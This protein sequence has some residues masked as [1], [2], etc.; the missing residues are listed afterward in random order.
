M[1]IHEYADAWWK[2]GLEDSL[3]QERDDVEEWFGMVRL[4]PAGSGYS[5]DPRPAYVEV[6][7]TWEP[8][9]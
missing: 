5:T 7:T 3:S 4:V 8:L 6:S 9:P 2:F 1:T